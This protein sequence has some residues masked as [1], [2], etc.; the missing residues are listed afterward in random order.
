MISPNW[1]GFVEKRQIL[2]NI[3]LVQEAIHS[4]K[5][6]GEKLMIIKI[7]MENAFYRVQHI[8]LFKVLRK[9]GFGPDFI[10][11]IATFIIS[12]WISHLV[13]DFPTTIFKASIGLHQGFPSLLYYIF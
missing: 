9:F 10:K 7:D 8:F 13:K 5:A 12:P 1:R 6:R 2:N 4:S 11:W 3:I